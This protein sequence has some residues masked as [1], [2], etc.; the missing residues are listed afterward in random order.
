MTT[1]DTGAP[2]PRWLAADVDSGRQVLAAVVDAGEASRWE[3]LIGV[4]HL[5]L[6]AVLE[7]LAGVSS[8]AIPGGAPPAPSVVVVSEFV[9]GRTLQG[10]LQKG[11]THPFKAVA[12]MLRLIDAITLVHDRGGVIG[13]LSPRSIVVEPTGR[14]IA[15]VL[16][17]NVS[18]PL[19]PYCSP[20]RLAGAGPSA[21]DDI[22]ALHASLY[23]AL[24][25]EPPFAGAPDTL[26]HRVRTGRPR[27]LSDFGV[28]EPLLQLVLER[29]LASDER[30]RTT[31]LPALTEALDAWERGR[32]PEVPRPKPPRFERKIVPGKLLEP[33]VFELDT[34]PD[35]A[36]IEFPEEQMDRGAPVEPPPMANSLA[37]AG[38]DATAPVIP[39]APL[40]PALAAPRQSSGGGGARVGL[41]IGLG[42]LV[43][44]AVAVAVGFMVVGRDSVPAPAPVAA[45][46]PSAEPSAVPVEL[47]PTQQRAICIASFFEIDVREREQNLD[48]VCSSDDYREISARL[49]SLARPE[50]P[51]QDQDAG[52]AKDAPGIVVTS[53][54]DPYDLAWYELAGTAIVRTTCCAEARP[55]ELPTTKGWC[56]Q[57]QGQVRSLAD[58]S[59]KPIDLSPYGRKFEDAVQC[60]YSTGTKRPYDYE[61]P[62]SEQQQRNFQRFLKYAAESDAKRSR[63]RWLR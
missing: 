55:I 24:T 58:A 6:A 39:A 47:S 42:V 12:W 3:A 54:T 33:L 5:H 36:A 34:L 15:P 59:R 18:P 17:T 31:E 52:A 32:E 29:G 2:S 13:T 41:F 37:E 57:L 51:E 45:P 27:P 46:P 38:I 26:L 43:L 50:R 53:D 22:W 4:E 20:E 63:M 1:V 56:Q 62:P 7:V 30:Q 11:Q 35:V 19:A 61:K 9:A 40:V 48:F 25:G 28:S 44:V 21:D 49:F 8:D 60:L 14:A 10:Q 23:A 16:A